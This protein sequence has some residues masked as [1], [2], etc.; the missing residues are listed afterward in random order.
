[1]V[2]I[3]SALPRRFN[4]YPQHVFVLEKKEKY[5]SDTQSYLELSYKVFVFVCVEVLRPSQLI[6]V[7]SSAVSLPVLTTLFPG[8]VKSSGQLT[9]TCAHSF[10]RK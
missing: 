10:S 5:F 4:K 8:Q 2:F 3:R 7:M 9:S 6:T 1:M